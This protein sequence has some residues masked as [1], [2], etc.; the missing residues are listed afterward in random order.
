M[1]VATTSPETVSR[2][3]VRA[4]G[5]ARGLVSWALGPLPRRIGLALL[6]LACATRLALIY[7]ARFNGDELTF[8]EAASGI[9]NGTS[10]PLLGPSITGG[11][12]CHPGPLF[13]YVMAIPLL[14]AK[15][16]EACNAFVAI[17][18]GVSVLL[19][20][21]ALRAYFG[22]AGATL[23]AVMMACSPWSTL[24][25]DRIWNPN[26]LI[27]F[28]AL[29]FWAACR[30]RQEPSLP[31]LI[32]LFM[33]A[34]GM[35]QFH[36]STP[37]VWL[38]L[39][40]IFLPSVRK[41]R[42][43]WPVVAFACAALLY[44]PMLL[45]EYRTHWEN[46]RLFLSE[47]GANTSDDWK[48]VPAWAFRLLTLDISYQQLHSYWGQHTEAEMLAFVIHG[49]SDFRWSP[50]RRFFLGLSVLFAAFALGVWVVRAWK[51]GRHGAAWIFL[52]AALV[53][54]AANTALLGL[55]HKPVYG[56]YVESLLPFY[57]VAFAVLGRAA[58]EWRGQLLVYGVAGLVCVGGVDAT[59]WVS[60]ELD[61]RGGLATIYGSIAAIKADRPESSSASLS[62]SYRVNEQAFAA[63]ADL[64][65][66]KL[67]LRGG[68]RY[69]LMLRDE[70][71]PAG[72]KLVQRLGS[73]TLYTWPT[74]T[75]AND[76][77]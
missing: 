64:S 61:A 70:A 35:P 75:R 63:V 33:S 25:S 57:F 56:H 18:G 1:Q 58:S 10:F 49:S 3:S 55:A 12:A 41:W 73:V 48:R 6:L 24:Y 40:P 42:W 20:W 13:Y 51:G 11:G 76:S 34:A 69:R 72:S 67:S 8:W 5:G 52:S 22:L 62:Y 2:F 65:G 28:V 14:F 7:T 38:A 71:P 36:M 74:P 23:A 54:L 19:Y 46:A 17:L 30:L 59:L 50:E 16:P 45:H 9:A 21:S 77:R 37:M 60:R 26:A 43:Y 4:D 27:F 39:T 15:A 47:T 29:A 32:L 66:G 53:G 44:V 68:P 31:V